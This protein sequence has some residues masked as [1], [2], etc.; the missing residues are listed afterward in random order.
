MYGSFLIIKFLFLYVCF[1]F[2]AGYYIISSTA[3]VSIRIFLMS[4]DYIKFAL[5][6]L[7]LISFVRRARDDPNWT[8]TTGLFIGAS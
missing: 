2:Y 1:Q 5:L 8:G 4:F 6:T 7:T 3:V